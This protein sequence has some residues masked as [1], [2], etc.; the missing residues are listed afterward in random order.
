VALGR[1]PGDDPAPLDVAA[2]PAQLGGVRFLAV[3]LQRRADDA[4]AG[5]DSAL[6]AA[7]HDV[8]GGQGSCDG[9]MP[10]MKVAIAGGHGQIALALTRQL[11]ARGDAVAGLIRNPAHAE[12]VAAAGGEPVRCDLEAGDDVAAAIA[13]SDA[14]VFAAG[15]GP[16]SGAERKWTV[17]YG[18]AVKLIAACKRDGIER[19]VIVSSIGADPEAPGDEGFGVYLRAKGRAD[20][21]LAASGLAYTIV[22]PGPLTDD[23]PTGRVTL[24]PD[25]PRGPITRADTAALVAVCLASPA[26]VGKTFVAV[27]GDTPIDQAVAGLP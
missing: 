3:A 1:S 17:D 20:A 16:G 19:Y 15:A 27:N 25:V 22:R 26:S 5:L 9:T 11:S 12:D 2:E 8:D 18:G 7:T 23:P 10:A 21:E 14:V 24:G 13:G 4:P 6:T